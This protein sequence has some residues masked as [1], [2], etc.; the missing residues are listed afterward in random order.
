MPDSVL[1]APVKYCCVSLLP[2]RQYASD[3]ITITIKKMEEFGTFNS[4]TDANERE[5][6]KKNKFLDV[7]IRSVLCSVLPCL[8][9]ESHSHSVDAEKEI[10]PNKTKIQK[11]YFLK[12]GLFCL[13][14]KLQFS[15]LERSSG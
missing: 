8:D 6:A 15:P 1:P 5:K 9:A 11:G 13:L 3:V 12:L 7:L 2:G 14:C 4:L 10:K